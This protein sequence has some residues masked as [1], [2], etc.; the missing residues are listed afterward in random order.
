MELIWS[1]TPSSGA[2]LARFRSFHRRSY[3]VKKKLVFR[4]SFVES[5]ESS[6]APKESDASRRCRPR[7]P[8][9]SRLEP[10]FYRWEA[11]LAAI[12]RQRFQANDRQMEAK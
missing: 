10:R 2:R 9:A 1:E 3:Q 7:G 12:R 5:N 8:E 6:P 11:D 4:A